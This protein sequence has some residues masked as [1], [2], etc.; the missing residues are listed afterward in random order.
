[1]TVKIANFLPDI[2][3]Y[4]ESINTSKSVSA[5]GL[6]DLVFRVRAKTGLNT[7]ICTAIVSLF[8]HEI[9][10][11]MLKGDIVTIRGLGKL[12]VSSPKH[13]N[14]KRVFPKF[15]PYKKLI[16]RMNDI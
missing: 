9:R 15:K 13:K 8:F 2:H 6:E 3:D 10:N 7:D 1:M 12:Y 14:K 4:L 5:K 11:S 16:R